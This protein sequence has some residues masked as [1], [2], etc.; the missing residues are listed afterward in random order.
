MWYSLTKPIKLGL[1]LSG[2]AYVVLEAIA[3]ENTKID[4]NAMNRLIEVLDRRVNGI[5]VAESSIQKLE[6]I[7][8]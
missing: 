7:E 8:L 1:D 2:G 4:N 6:I 3:D 5:G